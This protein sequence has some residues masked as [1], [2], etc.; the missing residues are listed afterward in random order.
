MW[1]FAFLAAIS[2]ILLMALDGCV[3]Q[4]Y[5]PVPVEQGYAPAYPPY[6]SET[7]LGRTS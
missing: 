1:T 5:S 6:Q 7:C 2:G 3:A 4:Q